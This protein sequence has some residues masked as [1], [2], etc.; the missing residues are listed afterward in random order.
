[1][2][3]GRAKSAKSFGATR[4]D[5]A[6]LAGVSLATASL[7]LNNH[8]RVARSTRRRV[9]EAAESLGYVPNHAAT[10][11][12]RTRFTKRDASFDQIGFIY[13]D[14]S[15]GALD[16]SCL[17]MMR[18]AEQELFGLG[19]ALIFVRLGE[20]AHWRKVERLVR[21][22]GVDGWLLAGHVDDEAANLLRAWNQPFV[23][24]G[25]HRCKQPVHHVDV[26]EP[27]VA[28]L[29]V[30]HLAALGHRRIGFIC[31]SMTYVYQTAM[32]DGFRRAVRELGL[33]ADESLIQPTCKSSEATI[34]AVLRPLLSQET[35]PTAIFA[36]EGGWSADV[37]RTLRA[38]EFQV[39]SDLSFIGCEIDTLA[40]TTPKVTRIETP[41]SQLGL[42]GA[43]MLRKIVSHP[44]LS[45][46]LVKLPPLLVEG[47]SCGSPPA[48]EVRNQQQATTGK[49]MT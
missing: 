23:I 48:R 32:L 24:L 3:H 39:P 4:L 45:P 34:D 12:I 1:M 16:P 28:R 49:A 11:L 33:D 19:A 17:A 38:L 43:R 29:A 41:I 36:A 14:R 35:P 9:A 5:V 42:E 21:A 8:G 20:P 30:Q 15:V 2:A 7:A 46:I 10:R 18:G 6:R 25:D 40:S 27:A 13:I 47:W 31:G 26:D 37:V 22:G 44:S